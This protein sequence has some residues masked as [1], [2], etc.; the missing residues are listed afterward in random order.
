MHIKYRGENMDS[1]MKSIIIGVVFL[2]ISVI[3]LLKTTKNALLGILLIIGAILMM[4]TGY[5][6]KNN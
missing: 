1:G 3:L 4:I 2:I 5:M 6:R